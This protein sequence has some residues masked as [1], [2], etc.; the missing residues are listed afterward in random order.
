MDEVIPVG[1][2]ILLDGERLS[3]VTQAAIE[4][5]SIHLVWR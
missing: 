5:C 4:P 2:M 3:L 1:E